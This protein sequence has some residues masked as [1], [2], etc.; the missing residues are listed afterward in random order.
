MRRHRATAALGAAALSA[1]AILALATSRSSV[2]AE[3]PPAY[4]LA[5]LPAGLDSATAL[6][7]AAAQ[8]EACGGACAIV[9]YAWTPR[10]PLSRA[11]IPHVAEAAR[12][13]GV[14][15]TLVA[16]DEL[17]DYASG[18]S[19]PGA[20]AA[21]P[22]ADAML[23][24][25]AL[26]HAPSLVV[27]RDG[28]PVGAAILGYKTAAAYESAIARRLARG[29]AEGEAAAAGEVL[30]RMPEAAPDAPGIPG[31]VAL[32]ASSA[33][34]G[35]DLRNQATPLPTDYQAV[36]VPGAYFRWV[37]GRNAVAYESSQ[38]VYLLDLADGQSRVA[39]GFIDFVPTPDGLYFVTPGEVEGG[40]TF[41]DADDVFDAVSRGRPAEAEP[42]FTDLTMRDQYPSVGILERDST[43]THYR[44]M[45]SWFESVVYRDYDVRVD[46]RSGGA[47]VRP[48]AEPVRPC[49]GVALSTPIMSQDGLEVAGRDEATGTTKIF[50]ILDGG[51][52]EAVADLG[53]PTSKVA[54]HSTRRRLAFSVPRRRRGGDESEQ[55]IFVLDRDA[56]DLARLPG[57]EEASR[58][59]FPDFVGDDSVIFLI[60]GSGSQRSSVFRVVAHGP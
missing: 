51:R 44:V 37:P 35:A 48:V 2:V 13:L 50:R 47:S 49:A 31:P 56:R 60:P 58:L 11:G 25:G 34:N 30:A 33:E 28:E 55:G 12:D 26:A 22:L 53:V 38:R 59:A 21:I 17:A 3:L 4:E 15:L 39:P 5:A 32:E 20:A 10:M 24:A 41:F 42:I 8:A 27:V 43:R 40:L 7:A 57:S 54:W 46:A 36:G 29:E 16:Y 23:V 9:V 14:G 52:C 1:A 18:T 19:A 6:V 45:T